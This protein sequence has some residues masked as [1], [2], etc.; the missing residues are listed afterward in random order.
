[1]QAAALVS[2]DPLDAGWDL[3]GAVEGDTVDL[4]PTESSTTSHASSPTQAA[5]EGDTVNLRPTQ[6]S[7][8]SRAS[9]PTQ[10]PTEP[11]PEESH[12]VEL[13]A[14]EPPPLEFEDAT[15]E[16][17]GVPQR[18]AQPVIPPPGEP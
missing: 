9:S 5:V 18:I 1:P 17:Y 14:D 13:E 2:L 7:T 6:S 8:T 4:R 12:T 3:E 15:R 11:P 16:Y 10:A